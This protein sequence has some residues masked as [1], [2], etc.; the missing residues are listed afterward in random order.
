[1]ES[2]AV[3]VTTEFPPPGFGGIERYMVKLAGEIAAA[4]HELIV[5]APQMPGD[6]AFD[7]A[8]PYPVIRFPFS[9][10]AQADAAH[11]WIARVAE[12]TVKAHRIAKDKC[13]IASS[14]IRSGVACAMLPKAV[15]GELAII[16][17]G[18]EVLSQRHPAKRAIMRATFARAD[19]RVANSAFTAAILKA[20][21]VRGEAVLARCGVEPRPLRR[22]TAAAP[23][24]LSVG[25]LVRRKGFDKTL[26]AMARLSLRFP[27]LRYEIVGVGP[28]EA[29]LRQLAHDLGVAPRVRFLGDVSDAELQEAYSRAWCFSLPTRRVGGDVEGFGIVY[30]EAAMAA[31]PSIGGKHSG[32]EDAIDDGRSGILVDGE[33]VAGIASALDVLLSNPS[34][35]QAMGS[36]GRERALAEFTWSG[37]ARTIMNALGRGAG[38]LC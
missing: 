12:A 26:E 22:Q 20:A 9:G 18:S 16:A 3:L 28:D 7:A 35:A 21:G 34:G 10:H 27:T 31:L 15:R 24:I 14:W 23:T 5:V 19:V 6:A 17:H 32:A 11:I 38:V 29:Y 4:G 13:T 25:R 8:L 2:M 30:L 33:D 1:M 37:A 36:Y